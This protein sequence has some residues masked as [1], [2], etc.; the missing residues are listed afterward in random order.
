VATEQGQ[1]VQVF[2]MPSCAPAVGWAFAQQGWRER[3]LD[4]QALVLQQIVESP[5]I[6][7]VVIGARFM[8][9][10]ITD[11]ASGFDAAL[12][13]TVRRLHDAG[14]AVHVLYPV[15]EL[16]Q[17]VP[18]AV[19]RGIAVGE[20]DDELARPIDEFRTN[21][22]PAIEFL[23]RIVAEESVLAIAPYQEFCDAA[24]CY[25]YREGVVL[26]HDE[27]HLSLSGARS[28]QQLFL[29]LFQAHLAA[30]V[31]ATAHDRASVGAGDSSGPVSQPN[32][33]LGRPSQ[34]VGSRKGWAADPSGSAQRVIVGR[35]HHQRVEDAPP[36]MQP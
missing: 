35:R 15:P 31:D 22:A 6:H 20:I 12:R 16:G 7:T 3:C 1:S 13:G 21:F 34:P 9:Y 23:D 14:K 24:Q 17:E 28:V 36:S 5:S 27:H 33:I 8:G 30:G 32:R 26:Y 29:P 25:F 10:P 4:F 11:P 19:G 2:T 18:L